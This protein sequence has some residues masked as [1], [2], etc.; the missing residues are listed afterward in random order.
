MYHA[1]MNSIAQRLASVNQ[2]VQVACDKAG[3]LRHTVG[4]L[5]VSKTQPASAIEE[6][7]AAGQLSFGENYLQ[8]ASPKIAHCP[9]A[10]WHFIGAIQSRKTSDIAA[11]FSWVHSVASLKVARRLA[12]QRNPALGPLKLMIQVN[13]SGEEAKSG[14]TP[15]AAA[16]LI[17]EILSL[18]NLILRG[19]MTIP[20]ATSDDALLRT[21]F[22][23]LRE[24]RDH[25]SQTQGIELPDLSMGMSGDFPIAIEEGATWIRIG[26]A[27]FGPRK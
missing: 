20:E 12:E 3:R 6:A 13:L 10:D 23:S 16:A 21:R 18:P 8:D 25:V 19:F 26:T 2:Q 11:G 17:P 24:L 7:M 4:L 22:R 14:L 9:S 1:P 27:V 5:A 15:D